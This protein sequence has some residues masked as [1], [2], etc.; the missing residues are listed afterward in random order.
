MQLETIGL[1]MLNM[2]GTV[3]KDDRGDTIPTY[4]SE[5]VITF[6]RAWTGA[7]QIL[8]FVIDYFIV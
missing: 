6:A 8:P 1:D 2:D 5:D 3:I 7:T 4:D